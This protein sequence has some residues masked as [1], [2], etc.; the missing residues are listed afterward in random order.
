MIQ[1]AVAP[2]STPAEMFLFLHIN[3]SAAAELIKKVNTARRLKLSNYIVCGQ[4]VIIQ[5][6]NDGDKNCSVEDR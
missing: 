1:T 5:D 4:L 6:N 3:T 2:P